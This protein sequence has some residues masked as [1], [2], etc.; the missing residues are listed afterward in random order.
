[1]GARVGKDG[2]PNKWLKDLWEFPCNI[3]WME[4]LG[5]R[6]AEVGQANT[7]SPSLFIPIHLVCL[8]NSIFLIVI[9]FHGFRRYFP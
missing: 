9:I 8:R 2:I 7:K 1:V 3:D 4:K 5:I 6:L